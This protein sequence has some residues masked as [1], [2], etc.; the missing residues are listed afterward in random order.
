[1][2][3]LLFVCCVFAVFILYYTQ[4]SGESKRNMEILRFA[5]KKT[6]AFDTDLSGYSWFRFLAV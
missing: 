5:Q 2:F 1:M 6:G 3:G 4:V